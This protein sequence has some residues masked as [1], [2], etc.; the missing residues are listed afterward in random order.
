[1]ICVRFFK[2]CNQAEEMMLLHLMMAEKGMILEVVGKVRVA[3]E[4]RHHQM[5]LAEEIQENK[6]V[7]REPE[8]KRM[9][10]ENQNNQKK[11]NPNRQQ[12]AQNQS[13][14]T[15]QQDR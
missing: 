6:E 11:M 3:T 9:A 12:K 4:R 7:R 13:H 14:K 5:K 8:A 15:H 10:M 2:E 1:M